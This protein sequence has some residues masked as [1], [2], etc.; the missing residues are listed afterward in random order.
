MIDRRRSDTLRGGHAF[1][2]GKGRED[3]LT[4]ELGS[5]RRTSCSRCTRLAMNMTAA[6][7]VCRRAR[8]ATRCAVSAW[9]VASCSDAPSSG[10]STGSGPLLAAVATLAHHM[11]SRLGM[12]EAVGAINYADEVGSNGRRVHSEETARLI[13]SEVRHLVEEA[14]EMARRVLTDS[15]RAL[16]QV[17]QAL[18]ERETLTLEEVEEIAG[19][20]AVPAREL[21]TPSIALPAW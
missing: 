4:H 16:D 21:R 19:H 13:D 14:G 17:A 5:T 20:A 15:R 2:G 6:R 1:V 12:S 10:G 3:R 9:P 18:M 11:V 7:G 8:L